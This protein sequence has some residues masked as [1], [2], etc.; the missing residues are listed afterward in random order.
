MFDSCRYLNPMTYGDYPKSMRDLVKDR[1]PKF[2]QLESKMLTK[3][4]DF[5]G[6][7][8]YY[9]VYAFDASKSPPPTE[10]D[11][12]SDPRVNTTCKFG[13]SQLHVNVCIAPSPR[14]KKNLNR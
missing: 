11:Y 2:T 9:A 6:L 3:S 5:I 8:Y 4:F 7:N 13:I 1:L 10:F 14:T 12:N